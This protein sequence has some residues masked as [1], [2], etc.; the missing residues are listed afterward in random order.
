MVGK[1]L[2]IAVQAVFVLLFV[3]LAISN[4]SLRRQLDSARRSSAARQSRFFEGDSIP[5]FEA[6]DRARRPVELSGSAQAGRVMVMFVPGCDACETVLGEI[7]QK[8]NRNVTVVSLMSQQMAA[9]SAKK[10]SP[11]TSLYFVDDIH[12]STLQSRA[13]VVP[14]ILRLGPDGKVAEVCQTY[15]TC[16]E[17]LAGI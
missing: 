3:A 11:D 2:L 5:S 13:R 7:A 9:A 8:P 6:R 12:R 10:L 4:F 17:H 14:Q 1:K 16:I 15:Q